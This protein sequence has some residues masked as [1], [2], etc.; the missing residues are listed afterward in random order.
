MPWLIFYNSGL[1]FTFDIPV[2]TK[3]RTAL[4]YA[5]DSISSFDLFDHG[6]VYF[7]LQ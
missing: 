3:L 7:F 6:P 2:M 4:E 1:G 5:A